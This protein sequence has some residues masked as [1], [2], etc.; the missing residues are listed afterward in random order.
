MVLRTCSL[1]GRTGLAFTLVGL[2]TRLPL[3]T[4]PRGNL[5]GHSS[6]IF[7]PDESQEFLIQ[8]V[9]QQT[10]SIHRTQKFRCFSI[11]GIY[12]LGL[13]SHLENKEHDPVAS[14]SFLPT[15]PGCDSLKPALL[16][17]NSGLELR[18]R[19]ATRTR[20]FLGAI[21]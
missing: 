20:Q 18:T 4:P 16:L 8:R 15:L 13:F 7:P 2:N 21:F 9:T 1:S 6:P 14:R 10:V 19:R 11:P 3:L 17:H 5:K 12:I